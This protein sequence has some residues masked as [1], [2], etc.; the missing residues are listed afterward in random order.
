[1]SVPFPPV[2]PPATGWRFGPPE[3]WDP[4]DDLVGAGADLEP[5]TVLEAYRHGVFP[6]PLGGRRDPLGWWSPVGRGVLE[7]G[8]L[9]VS[10]SLRR[11]A[12]DYEIRVD[13]AFEEVLT[14]CADPRRPG[15][16]IDARIRATYGRLHRDGWVHSV[17]AWREGRLAGGLYGVGVG[18]LFAGE[19]MFH[20]ERDASKVA[21]LGLVRLLGEARG[22]DWLVDV[23]WVTPHL[24]SLGVREVPREA[25]LRRLPP[26]LAA[27]P[28]PWRPPS[29]PVDGPAGPVRSA[30]ED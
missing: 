18:A 26:L 2:E 12:R 11:A 24:A 19:S 28:L 25:Y 14:A 8:S 9:K 16:W 20:R 29:S 23:Q 15:G 4:E 5:G 17:E 22:E 21:L 13:T 30:T 1:M 6:M 3:R 7:P 10:R 27:P